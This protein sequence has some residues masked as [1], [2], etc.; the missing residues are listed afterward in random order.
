MIIAIH[1]DDYTTPDRPGPDASSPLWTQFLQ[2]AG[3]HVRTVDVFRADILDQLRGCDAFMW[4]H[5]HLPHHRQIARRL[6]PVVE[7]ELG[8]QVYPDQ[9]TCWHYDDKISQYYL[10][11]AARIPMP[12]T[13][14]WFSFEQAM[15][16]A[17]SARYPFV[18][19]LWSGTA[20]Q[21]VHL[22]QDFKEAERWIRMLF[23]QG[24]AGMNEFSEPAL[25]R[26]LKRLR[27]AV[28][29][30]A[31]GRFNRPWE[32]HRNYLLAQEFVAGN[33][34]DI[35]VVVI[36]KRAFAKRRYNRPG[37]F[38]ASGTT[39]VDYNPAG[40]D[41]NALHL[42]FR[43]AERLGTQ[44]LA[45]D[46]LRRRDE[47]LITE[48]SYTYPSRPQFDCPGHWEK[49]DDG[50]VWVEGHM[51][52]EEAQVQDFLVRLEERRYCRRLVCV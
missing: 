11:K 32:L 23:G 42:A 35:R 15:S 49:T 4:R 41:V 21:N 3:H 27:A 31:K 48:I 7:R 51:W 34:Y 36:G 6:L 43:A 17:E 18:I 1:P 45:F 50:L 46:I 8:L 26:V 24:V 2:Q 38:R 29:V 44:S 39:R 52:P 16:W 13:W 10:F 22:V 40:I 12:D 9:K 25:K 19:K 30:L 47:C 14:V 5:G 20:S 33:E 37:D 28:G